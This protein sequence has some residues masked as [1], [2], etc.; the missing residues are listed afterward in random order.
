MIVVSYSGRTRRLSTECMHLPYSITVSRDTVVV[1]KIHLSCATR[2]ALQKENEPSGKEKRP[3]RNV[4]MY[5]SITHLGPLAA[6]WPHLRC[7][8][9]EVSFPV[10]T[11]NQGENGKEIKKAH[12]KHRKLG[13]C[14]ISRAPFRRK[15]PFAFSILLLSILIYSD[16]NIPW[17]LYRNRY[18]FWIF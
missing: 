12:A 18:C 1:G 7:C 2:H 9:D 5:R 16:I 3:A 10:D 8:L 14:D 11:K 4:A 15:Y 13:F 17:H 6:R